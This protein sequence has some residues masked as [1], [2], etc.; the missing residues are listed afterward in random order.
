MGSTEVPLWGLADSSSC[1]F[2]PW[3][4]CLHSMS[5]G[6]YEIPNASFECAEI[7]IFKIDRER[8]R[9]SREFKGKQMGGSGRAQ[10]SE[11]VV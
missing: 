11:G 7:S 1:W 9:K 6:I 5:P 2:L 3:V 10:E 8:K 4:Q